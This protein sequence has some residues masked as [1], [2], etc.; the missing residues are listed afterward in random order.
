MAHN[1]GKMLIAGDVNS[2]GF[3]D[4]FQCFVATCLRSTV[5]IEIGMEAIVDT[6]MKMSAATKSGLGEHGFHA[7]AI[8]LIGPSGEKFFLSCTEELQTWGID[9]FGIILRIENMIGAWAFHRMPTE[10]PGFE[11]AIFENG[12]VDAA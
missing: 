11:F 1:G 8:T 6:S 7:H 4:K 12:E 5:R 2:F 3:G 9:D 10:R